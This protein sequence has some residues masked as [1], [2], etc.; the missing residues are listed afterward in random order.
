MTCHIIEAVTDCSKWTFQ[1]PAHLCK[2][3]GEREKDPAAIYIWGVPALGGQGSTEVAQFLAKQ[4]RLPKPLYRRQ[5][6][7]GTYLLKRYGHR[8]KEMGAVSE[9]S[10][11]P[12]QTGSCVNEILDDHQPLALTVASNHHPL[13]RAAESRAAVPTDES[14]ILF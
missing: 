2:W 11:L 7:K 10:K 3:L 14:A 1:N 12:S 6:W 4:L 5:K 8:S 13:A 9:T